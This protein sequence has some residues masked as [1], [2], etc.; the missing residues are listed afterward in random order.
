MRCGDTTVLAT[1]VSAPVPPYFR[2]DFRSIPFTVDYREKS[3]AVGRIPGGY[4]KREGAPKE[5]EMLAARRLERALRPLLPR[6]FNFQTDISVSVLSADGAHDP[7]VLAINAA[8]AALA[9]SD[10]PWGGPVGAARVALVNGKIVVNPS[11]DIDAQHVQLSMLVAAT[12]ERITLLEATAGV[13]EKSASKNEKIGVSEEEFLELLHAGVEAARALLPAQRQVVEARGCAK[14]TIALAGADPAA[15]RKVFPLVSEAAQSIL[16]SGL[17]LTCLARTQA[18]VIAKA[19]IADAMRAAGSWR[20]EFARVPGS[21]CVT[22]TDIDH[23]FSAAL[24]SELRSLAI[25][26]GMRLDGRGLIDLRSLKIESDYI[27]VVH[28]SALIDA[29]DTQSL[30]TATVGNIAEQQKIES[31]IGGDSSKRLSVHFSLPEYATIEGA[32]R[33]GAA[34][35]RLIRHE[36]DR[37]SFVERA[38]LPVLPPETQFP[39]AVRINAET[40]AADGG[41]GTAAVCGSGV[42]MVDAGIP[43][44]SLV[45]AVSVGLVSQ[46]GA[47]NGEPVAS[48]SEGVVQPLG[49]YE[50]I[51]D[52][53]GLEISSGDMEIRIAGTAD[54]I[55]ACQLD[56]HLPGGITVEVVEEAVQR[57]K[58]GRVRVLAEMEAALPPRSSERA[59]HAPM[60]GR[61]SVPP[62]SLGAVIG[63]EGCI[64]RG[65]QAASGSKVHIKDDGELTVFAPSTAQFESTRSALRA[66]AGDTLE[67]GRLYTARVVMVK[68]FGAFVQVPGCD[69]RAMLH[70]SEIAVERIRAVEDYLKVGDEVEVVFMGRDNRGSLRVS[71][72]AAIAMLKEGNSGS[73]TSSS[74]SNQRSDPKN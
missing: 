37:S 69:V 41:S 52:P 8:S 59:P 43:L 51:M 48:S 57:A 67:R 19:K 55:T 58:I 49:Q 68:D 56:V 60:M 63:K 15:A 74:S 29:G 65:I 73:S 14:L 17:D 42:A 39:F 25:Q 71:R 10:V 54:G 33:G 70:I 7:E 2:R 3:Y 16:R 11:P 34:G 40:F 44:R 1:V 5:H 20:A 31:L 64:I 47:S 13:G 24:S 26:E 36:I 62:T 18:L 21:G 53:A 27:P 4:N 30:C 38:L 28:G 22:A 45:A 46:G 66:A 9:A 12:D 35:G 6:G 32:E 50:L 72:K 23:A 61:V